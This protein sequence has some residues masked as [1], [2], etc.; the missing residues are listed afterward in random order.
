MSR[1]HGRRCC[2]NQQSGKIP[3][4]VEMK[5]VGYLQGCQVSENDKSGT[6]VTRQSNQI[7]HTL[8]IIKTVINH[9]FPELIEYIFGW[10]YAINT[11]ICN[12]TFWR[13]QHNTTNHLIIHSLITCIDILLASL[14]SRQS[15]QLPSITLYQA[16]S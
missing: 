1:N 3:K 11:T 16:C 13:V 4:Y 10:Q 12:S 6:L 5:N 7:N 9:I 2:S 15:D 14:S 8:Y